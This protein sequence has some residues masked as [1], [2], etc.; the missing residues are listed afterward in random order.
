VLCRSRLINDGRVGEDALISILRLSLEAHHD[1]VTVLPY[2]R[3]WGAGTHCRADGYHDDGGAVDNTIVLDDET[4][5]Q[6]HVLLLVQPEGVL[7]LDL[8]STNGTL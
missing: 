6:C 1:P 5:S 4:I 3:R 8:D 7:L 2:Y